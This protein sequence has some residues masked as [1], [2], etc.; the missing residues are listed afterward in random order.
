MSDEIKNT[1]ASPSAYL[2]MIVVV[3]F[4]GWVVENAWLL[5]RKGFMDNRNMNLPFLLGYGIACVGIFIILGKPKKFW[6]YFLEC[7]FLISAGEIIMGSLMEKICGFEWW[8]Y[9]SIPLHITKYTSIPTSCA[10]ALAVTLFMK[11]CFT[12]LLT[13][14]NKHSSKFITGLASVLVIVLVAD[15]SFS[16]VQ[17]YK[18]HGLYEKWQI[19]LAQMPLHRIF[20]APKI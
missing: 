6:I 2:F 9:N 3:S 4:M 16:F 12:P 5:L 15:L 13:V 8:N 17:M 11:Y 19:P 18:I 20:S 14:F 1:K 7:F 10:F